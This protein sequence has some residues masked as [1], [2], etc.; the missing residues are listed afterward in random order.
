M[1]QAQ[2]CNKAECPNYD[3]GEC[4][5]RDGKHYKL[6]QDHINVWAE[7][8]TNKQTTPSSPAPNFFFLNKG[9]LKEQKPNSRKKKVVEQNEAFQTPTPAPALAAGPVLPQQT[10]LALAPESSSLKS[11]IDL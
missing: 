10:P 3:I 2:H 8:I 1:I 6:E 9:G 11:L 4:M 5:T 7:A